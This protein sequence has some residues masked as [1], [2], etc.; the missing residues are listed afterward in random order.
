MSDGTARPTGQTAGVLLRQHRLRAGLTQEALVARTGLGLRTLR[1]LECGRV[2]RPHDRSVAVL[3][4]TL[5]LSSGEVSELR[6][7][8][9][10]TVTDCRPRVGVLGPLLVTRGAEPINVGPPIR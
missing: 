9:A 5:Q 1:D 8:F 10:S 4:A 7:A 3:A 6:A 2:R